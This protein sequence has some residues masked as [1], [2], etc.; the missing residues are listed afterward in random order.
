MM[1]KRVLFTFIVLCSGLNANNCWKIKNSDIR[2]LCESKFEAKQNCWLIKDHD[3]KAYCEAVV[4][5]QNSCWK[6]KNSDAKEMCIAE[7]RY[8]Q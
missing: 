1:S 8:R 7:K 4:Y 2:A 6:I 5:G 3:L